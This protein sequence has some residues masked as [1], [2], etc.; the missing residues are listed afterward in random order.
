VNEWV[1]V[2]LGVKVLQRRVREIHRVWD[3]QDDTD[4]VPTGVRL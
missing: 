3:D 1:R 2:A 4:G